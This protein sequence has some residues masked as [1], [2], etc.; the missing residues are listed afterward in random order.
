MK[1]MTAVST[2]RLAAVSLSVALVGCGSSTDTD[3]ETSTTSS[4][5]T[6]AAASIDRPENAGPNKTINDYI[7]ENN[8]AETPFKPDDP[9]TP[10]FDFPFPPGWRDAGPQTPDWAYGAIVY[11]KPQN[12]NDL[13]SIIAIASKLTGNVD[14]AKILEYPPSDLENLPDF[15]PLR[16]PRKSTLGGFD[17]I[18]SSGTY[19]SDGKKRFVAQKTVVVPTED[20]LYALQLSADALD[21]QQGV[22]IEA[23]DLIDEQTTITP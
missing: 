20:G 17:A 2:A 4:T 21:G 10:N 19:M 7:V 16:E 6:S 9:G 18:Q 11:D 13:P 15:E 5:S 1:K 12:P 22:I 8:I 23:A 14:P 3:T